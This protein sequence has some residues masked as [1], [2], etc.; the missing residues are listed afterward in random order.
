MAP[1]RIVRRA[2]DHVWLIVATVFV[3]SVVVG[4]SFLGTSDRERINRVSQETHAALCAFKI[5]LE[6]RVADTEEYLEAV[7]SGERVLPPGITRADIAETLAGRSATLDSLK[8][9]ECHR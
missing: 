8:G 1:Q 3:V 5:D 6:D 4:T 7:D 2:R 9:L